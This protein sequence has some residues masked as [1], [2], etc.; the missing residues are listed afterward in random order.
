[1]FSSTYQLKAQFEQCG[2]LCCCGDV[3]WAAFTVGPC[4]HRIAYKPGEKGRNHVSR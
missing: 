2:R 1:M 3:G 4:E